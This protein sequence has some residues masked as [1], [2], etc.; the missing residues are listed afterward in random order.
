MD[1]YCEDIENILNADQTKLDTPKDYVDRFTDTIEKVF[2]EKFKEQEF[3]SDLYK[4]VSNGLQASEWENPL[5][6]GLKLL[7][8]EPLFRVVK[9]GG[10]SEEKHGTDIAIYIRS[11]LLEREDVIAIQ[12]KD[13]KN[14]VSSDVFAQI[15]KADEYFKEQGQKVIEKILIVIGARKDENQNLLKNRGD[16]EILFAEDVKSL[17]AKIGLEFVSKKILSPIYKDS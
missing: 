9:K 7:Y 12:V 17:L 16:V 10:C 1:Y 11:F 2:H 14:V 5:V 8:P 13:Y 3:K 15:N 6:E 4:E